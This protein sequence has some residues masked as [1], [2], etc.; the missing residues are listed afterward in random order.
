VFVWLMFVYFLL[1]YRFSECFVCAIG[2]QHLPFWLPC[3]VK[4]IMLLSHV[5]FALLK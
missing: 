1:A 4:L 3:F 5:L 2:G